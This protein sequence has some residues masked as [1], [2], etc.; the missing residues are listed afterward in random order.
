[1]TGPVRAL[2]RLLLATP[3]LVG[4][5]GPAAA[6]CY[7]I[8]GCTDRD[9]FDRHLD[10][11]GSRRDGPN[12]RFLREIRHGILAQN[13]HCADPSD[14]A[15]GPDSCRAVDADRVRLSPTER[16]NI[17]VIRRVERMKGCGG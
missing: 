3:A 1:M 16:A 4:L 2:R 15:A 17:A 13:G 14:E 5:A 6:D 10:Y 7:D 9:R 8:L 11:L 12:C